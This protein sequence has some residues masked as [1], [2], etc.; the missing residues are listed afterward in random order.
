MLIIGGGVFGLSTAYALTLRPRWASTRITLVDRSAGVAADRREG[1]VA[2]ADAA[3]IDS[4][5][6]VRADYSHPAYAALGAAAQRAW[7][8]GKQEAE[9]AAT[10]AAAAAAAAGE[11]GVTP[12]ES[13]FYGAGIYHEVG[14][15]L[16]ANDDDAA[17][18]SSAAPAITTAAAAAAA[19]PKLKTGLDYVKS[20]WA[21]V[22]TLSTSTPSSPTSLLPAQLQLLPSA[23]SISAALS[24][25]ALAPPAGA[26]WGYANAAS[27]WADA[28]AAMARLLALVRADG[29][30]RLVAGR[31][32]RRLAYDAGQ[33]RVTGAVLEGDGDGDGDGEVL[34]ADLVLVAAGAWSPKLVDLTGR[35]AATGQCMAYVELGG[36]GED[37]QQQQKMQGAPVVLNMSSGLFVI[38]PP[39]PPPKGAQPTVGADAKKSVFK[40]ARHAYG[41]L[42][43]VTIPHPLA[44]TA[45]AQRRLDDES[46]SSSTPPPT[47]VVSLPQTF[48]SSPAPLPSLPAEGLRSLRGALASMAPAL[49]DSPFAATRLCWYAD[50]V[51]GDF[52]VARHPGW[53]GL[54]VAT[55]GS[56]HAF[57]FLPVLG[58]RVADVLEGGV[59]DELARLWAWRDDRVRVGFGSPAGSGTGDGSRGG[60][61]GMVLWDELNKDEQASK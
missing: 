15:C 5:R 22:Q 19:A 53:R 7:R 2:S 4:S 46:A 24:A 8:R 54:A 9:D 1:N 25:H 10:A 31:E 50:T 51:D 20:S 27:G 6:V 26:A 14:L 45:A 49:A 56:G 34:E 16:V 55:G 58:E 12:Q 42:N 61:P 33:G 40:V 28:A 21:N 30:V 47:S 36:E 17:P 13:H 29:R 18:S 23:S 11:E 38:P 32:V 48:L 3:S 52:L 41:Y 60:R 57:K 43:P 37:T 44:V 39:P 59:G 35:V